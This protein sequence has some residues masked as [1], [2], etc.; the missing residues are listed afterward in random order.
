MF[1]HRYRLT[2]TYLSISKLLWTDRDL[3]DIHT[4]GMPMPRLAMSSSKEEWAEAGH[5]L[6]AKGRYE[7]AMLD[8]QRAGLRQEK[9]VAFAFLLRQR[10]EALPADRGAN[11]I[12]RNV[13]YIKAADAFIDAVPHARTIEEKQSYRRNAGGAFERGG[14]YA[15]AAE[16]Y[17]GAEQYDLAAQLFRRA[18]MFD[19]ALGVVKNHEREMSDDVARGVRDVSKIHYLRENKIA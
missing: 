16:A 3:V 14:E 12:A 17:L 4:P 5:S 1:I 18:G 8:F 10:A 19:E 15:K 13:A 7:E 11:L 6:F 2:L 9:Q